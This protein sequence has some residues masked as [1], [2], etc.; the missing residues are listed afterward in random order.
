MQFVRKNGICARLEVSVRPSC[1]STA[2]DA[3]RCSGHL[4]DILAHVFIVI[5]ELFQRQKHKLSVY[6]TPYELVYT[7]VLFLIDQV[8]S[9]TR[10]RASVRFCDVYKG[11]KY[12]DWLSAIVN[13]IMTY[14]GLAGETKL[15]SLEK[16]LLDEKRFNPTNGST[17]SLTDLSM[18]IDLSLP[19]KPTVIP[20]T[21]WKTLQNIR[22]W[23]CR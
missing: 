8:Q 18:N 22:D 2:G 12:S 7:K 19:M 14:I 4:I 13:A 11:E 15:R 16:W 20:M 1:H 21:T 3:L 10:F 9:L 17:R 6:T 23:P 5:H